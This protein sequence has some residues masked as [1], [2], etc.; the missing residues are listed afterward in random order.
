M[1]FVETRFDFP[2]PL[3]YHLSEPRAPG[4]VIALHGYQDHALSML[5]RLGW[6]HPEKLPFRLLAINAPFPVPVWTNEGFKEAYSWYFRDTTRDLTYV[7]P[8]TT[9]ERLA[10][11]LTDLKLD[12]TPKVLFGFSQGGFLAPYLARLAR[13]VRGIVGFGCG[14]NAEAYDVLKPLPVYGLHGDQDERV[15]LERT[16]REYAHVASLG[17]PGQFRVL[18]GVRHRLDAETVEPVVRELITRCLGTPA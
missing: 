15:S 7:A 2:L 6:D 16:R 17:F 18:P 13:E 1:K 11:L 8:A 4:L 9:A 12:D 14:F 5:R 10:R 3:R